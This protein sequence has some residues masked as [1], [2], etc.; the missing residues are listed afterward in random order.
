MVG[1]K[2]DRLV[3][4][5]SHSLLKFR[6]KRSIPGTDDVGRPDRLIPGAAASGQSLKTHRSQSCAGFVRQFRRTVGVEGI[7]RILR[8]KDNVL[9][10]YSNRVL[11]IRFGS[12]PHELVRILIHWRSKGADVH[13]LL[14]VSS[15]R[16]CLADHD[17]GRG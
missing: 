9:A 14:H 8:L 7:D 12:L 15:P 6:M 13:Q 1:F 10:L 4:V 5:R 3:S 11:K 17:P 16:G 2:P